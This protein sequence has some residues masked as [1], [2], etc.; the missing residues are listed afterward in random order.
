MSAQYKQA[1]LPKSVLVVFCRT[2]GAEKN[3][4]KKS[5]LA[6]IPSSTTAASAEAKSHRLFHLTS[7]PGHLV[8]IEV[9]QR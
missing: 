6:F 1:R 7:H 5:I 2:C 9:Y 4:K 8:E 3:D